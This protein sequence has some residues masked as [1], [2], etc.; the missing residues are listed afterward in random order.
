MRENILKEI[1]FNIDFIIK[2]IIPHKTYNTS[3]EVNDGV[4][5]ESIIIF[6]FTIHKRFLNS[7]DGNTQG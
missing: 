6:Y 4:D 1:N 7:T 5:G 3:I 2:L